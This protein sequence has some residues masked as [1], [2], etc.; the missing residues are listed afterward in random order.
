MLD[1]IG[2]DST[3]A[4]FE[5]VPESLRLNSLDLPRGISEMEALG[6]V[7]ELGRSAREQAPELSFV[8]GGAYE[9]FTPSVVDAMIS[10]SEFYTA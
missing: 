1:T 9:H 3:E 7:Q 8:G 4:L 6:L 5:P 2:I 10:R